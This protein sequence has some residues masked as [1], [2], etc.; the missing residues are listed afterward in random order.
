MPRCCPAPFVHWLWK[1]FRNE[2]GHHSGDQLETGRFQIGMSVRFQPG[3]VA[4]FKSERWPAS[5]GFPTP[6]PVGALANP[7]PI[8][9]LGVTQTFTPEEMRD[10]L[11]ALGEPFPPEL[12]EWRVTNTT[13]DRRG[14]RGLRSVDRR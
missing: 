10:R 8:T 14:N 5:S 7:I 11:A 13:R 2:N 9:S 12:V 3:I 1:S 6:A 4:G